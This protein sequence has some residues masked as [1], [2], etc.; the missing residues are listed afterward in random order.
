[1]L[2][3]PRLHHLLNRSSR[4]TRR[5]WALWR[6]TGITLVPALREPP[7]VGETDVSQVAVAGTRQ[8]HTG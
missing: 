8:G 6:H 7:S 2:P 4:T 5:P 3:V 1:M